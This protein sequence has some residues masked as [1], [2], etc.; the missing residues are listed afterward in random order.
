[1][2]ACG[3]YRFS[4]MVQFEKLTKMW[5][6]PTKYL[7]EL[8]FVPNSNFSS[9]NSQ[10]VPVHMYCSSCPYVLTFLSQSFC[11][12]V[13]PDEVLL[14]KKLALLCSGASWQQQEPWGL[15]GAWGTVFP[16]PAITLFPVLV[17]GQERV[18]V[19]WMFLWSKKM[20][21]EGGSLSLVNNNH[22][23]S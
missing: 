23:F 1:M 10:A 8:M 21:F 19:P 5:S 20:F 16:S 22:T 17:G 2:R 13:S 6:F 11:R 12:G 7:K 9:R 3:Q 18:C 14:D 4:K 15:L